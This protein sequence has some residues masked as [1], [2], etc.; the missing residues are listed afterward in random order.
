MRQMQAQLRVAQLAQQTALAQLRVAKRRFEVQAVL[1]K[2]VLQ[3]QTNLEQAND[4]YRQAP[5]RFL[6]AQ[7]E[8]E[9]ALGE[10][11]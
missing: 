2:D 8:F 7:A 6:A 10:D 5:A 4:D 11:Q 3:V 1:L 9:H